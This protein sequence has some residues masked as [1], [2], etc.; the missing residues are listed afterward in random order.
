[1]FADQ[2]TRGTRLPSGPAV[3]KSNVHLSAVYRAADFAMIVHL[4]AVTAHPC[5]L[6]LGRKSEISL[7]ARQKVIAVVDDDPSTLDAIGLLLDAHGFAAQLFSSAEAFFERGVAKQIDC[8][9]LDIH[10]GGISGI[11]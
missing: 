6:R 8:L 3:M 7:L 5:E 9:I 1:M 10:L 4:K 11:E 2:S